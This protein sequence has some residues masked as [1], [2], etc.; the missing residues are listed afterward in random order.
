MSQCQIDAGLMKT[1][2]VNTIHV[3]NVDGSRSH[4]GCMQAF[5]SQGIYVWLELSTPLH[6]MKPV[7]L[8]DVCES[9][10][11]LTIVVDPETAVDCR[12]F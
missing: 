3:Y 2:G 12:A 10:T 8:P 5:D 4:D 1:L 9:R 6:S 7:R 11:T